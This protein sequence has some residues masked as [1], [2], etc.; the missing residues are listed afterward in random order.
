MGMALDL[1]VRTRTVDEIRSL[2]PDW[3]DIE[4][5]ESAAFARL[6]NADEW[7]GLATAISRKGYEAVVLG[8]VSSLDA[9]YYAHYQN[10]RPIRV[11]V[12]GW[13]RQERT[14][15]QVSG[16]RQPWEKFE[17]DPRV[18]L[19]CFFDGRNTAIAVGEYYRFSGVY[20]P[21]PAPIA[22]GKKPAGPR[23]KPA[24]R[25]RGGKAKKPPVREGFLASN[26]ELTATIR[27]IFPIHTKGLTLMVAE[28]PRPHLDQG[29]IVESRDG[30]VLLL[31]AFYF[32]PRTQAE[33]E[34]QIESVVEQ[35]VLLVSRQAM[36]IRR[37]RLFH[38]LRAVAEV[39]KR[40][41][42]ECLKANDLHVWFPARRL[43]NEALVSKGDFLA[44]MSAGEKG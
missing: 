7:S 1:F 23:K 27:K 26:E 38:Y 13:D 20:E 16:Q 22:H 30:M 6:S 24:A 35:P 31:H 34:L 12:Y 25:G 28:P 3:V 9:F 37:D 40:Q 14:W 17:K 10:G 39:V 43:E 8:F 21:P 5:T 44:Q 32:L 42:I 41:P 11:L 36:P 4:L 2:V 29:P 15:E 18:G 19:Q 33:D